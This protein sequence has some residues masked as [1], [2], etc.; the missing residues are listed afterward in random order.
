MYHHR[1]RTG[2]PTARLTGNG[3]AR[4]LKRNALPAEPIVTKDP[5]ALQLAPFLT[6]RH[7]RTVRQVWEDIMRKCAECDSE[8]VEGLSVYAQGVYPVELS[9]R[10]PSLFSRPLRCQSRRLPYLRRRVSDSGSP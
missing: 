6:L 3:G 7:E 10:K 4:R 5:T 1:N 2:A 8:L 9:K